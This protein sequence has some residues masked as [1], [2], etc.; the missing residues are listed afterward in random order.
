MH[1]SFD[2]IVVWF[3]GTCV[4]ER[5][6]VAPPPPPPPP[7]PTPTPRPVPFFSAPTE[8]QEDWHAFNFVVDVC[9]LVDLAARFLTA[10]HDEYANRV[11]YEPIA[12]ARNYSRGLLVFDL[13]ASVPLTIVSFGYSVRVCVRVGVRH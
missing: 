6:P 9:F 11:V 12:I 4:A 7:L 5:D 1:S 13:I 8:R 2:H 10:Y 3:C